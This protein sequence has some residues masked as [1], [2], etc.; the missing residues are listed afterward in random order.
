MSPHKRE[1]RNIKR[2]Y[3][4]RRLPWSHSLRGYMRAL[5]SEG[6]QTAVAWCMAKGIRWDK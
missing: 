3:R 4:R 5:A 2:A 6:D 1:V